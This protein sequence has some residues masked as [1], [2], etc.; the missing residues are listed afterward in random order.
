MSI[1]IY[2]LTYSR[3]IDKFFKMHAPIRPDQS[4]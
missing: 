3:S 2:Q 1:N 4:L